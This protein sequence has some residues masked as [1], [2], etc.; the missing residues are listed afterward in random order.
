MNYQTTT[1][2][3][4]S[5]LY[6]DKAVE[7]YYVGVD[8]LSGSSYVDVLNNGNGFYFPLLAKTM[9]GRTMQL[10]NNMIQYTFYRIV[11]GVEDFNPVTISET[12]VGEWEIWR[13]EEYFYFH[14]PGIS[15]RV[16]I[17][18]HPAFYPAAIDSFITPKSFYFTTNEG[19][20]V[21][22]NTEL[23]VAY[24]SLDSQVINLHSNIKAELQAEQTY[25]DPDDGILYPYNIDPSAV[26]ALYN[27]N[28]NI[29]TGN[30]YQRVVPAAGDQANNQL[31]VNGN[32]FVI[33]GS[34]LPVTNYSPGG[35]TLNG[36][37]QVGGLTDNQSYRVRN[38]QVSIFHNSSTDV[39]GNSTT[40]DNPN[41]I[42]HFNN[43]TILG[44]TQTPSV[45]FSTDQSQIEASIEL[46]SRNSGGYVGIGSYYGTQV[47][48]DN[49]VI[50][51][52]TIAVTSAYHS[53][54]T[55]NN[56]TIY[57]SWAN[58]IYGHGF[59][60]ISIQNSNIGTS[61]GAAIHLEDTLYSKVY[62]QTVL[63]DTSTVTVNNWVSGEESWFKAYAM[64]LAAM[65]LKSQVNTQVKD[66]NIGSI[67][68][69]MT[70]ASTG[71]TS[72]KMNFIFLI[73]PV[74]QQLSY[75]EYLYNNTAP[76]LRSNFGYT[77][78]VIQAV[79]STDL[80]YQYDM[81]LGDSS[82]R[83]VVPISE[84]YFALTGQPALPFGEIIPTALP[85]GTSDVGTMV[86]NN[87]LGFQADMSSVGRGHCIAVVALDMYPQPQ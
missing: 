19:V 46:M 50:G 69:T 82:G 67:L 86:F 54:A 48:L 52:T 72:R 41:G 73:M 26:V 33:D 49:V 71:L 35:I 36:Y 45:N 44:N 42:V 65:R 66:A 34:D 55:I 62:A 7:P 70:D 78:M 51:A 25:V 10:D 58:S 18:V 22:T 77:D 23:Q 29:L 3:I 20:N 61:G 85:S 64:E 87:Q 2:S 28:P 24:A 17:Q 79:Q 6:Y 12:T 68:R 40:Y 31:V 5:S 75:D 8:F 53:I 21:Y 1:A 9:G 27:S 30:V 83:Y 74:A 76:E 16:Q 60:S 57:N 84:D 11:D 63:Y 4:E 32:Y 47:N 14:I 56:A 81:P 80:P 15:Y 13:N 38:V 43:L 59:H 39:A 37:G